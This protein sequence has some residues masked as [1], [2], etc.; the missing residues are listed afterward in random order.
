MICFVGVARE[1]GSDD[2]DSDGPM[3]RSE[4]WQMETERIVSVE[5]ILV[6][7]FVADEAKVVVES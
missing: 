3:P 4:K 2:D 6:K 5:I 7:A 1:T